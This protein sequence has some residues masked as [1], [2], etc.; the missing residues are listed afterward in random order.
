MGAGVIT[1]GGWGRASVTLTPPA[2]ADNAMWESPAIAVTGVNAND[3]VSVG[4]PMNA[5]GLVA[6]GYVSAFGQVKV[7]ITNKSGAAVTPAAATW[8]V[9]V[10]RK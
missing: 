5:T 6:T 7:Q 8:A 4:P 1:L 3:S 10:F 2:I 9:S